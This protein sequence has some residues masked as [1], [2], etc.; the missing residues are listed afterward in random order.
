MEM[1]AVA[2]DGDGGGGGDGNDENNL[3][4]VKTAGMVREAA[5]NRNGQ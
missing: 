5:D 2:V 4:T 1:V 3:K